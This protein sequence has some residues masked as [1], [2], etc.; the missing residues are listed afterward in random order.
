MNSQFQSQA[1]VFLSAHLYTIASSS[2]FTATGVKIVQVGKS[3]SR[4]TRFIK[5]REGVE[6][7]V[8]VRA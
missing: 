5:M 3:S 4:E 8:V 6:R 7:S 1:S 2:D